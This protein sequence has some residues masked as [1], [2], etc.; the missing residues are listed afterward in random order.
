MLYFSELFELITLLNSAEKKGMLAII[1]HF[2]FCNNIISFYIVL[3]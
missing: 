1:N 3:G 2:P